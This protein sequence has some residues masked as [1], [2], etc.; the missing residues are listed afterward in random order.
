MEIRNYKGGDELKIVELF[1][2]VFNQKLSLDQW[3]WRFA[4]NP[5]D[6]HLISLMWDTD[7]LVGHYA[8]S[9]IL[10][11]VNGENCLTVHSLAYHDKF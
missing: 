8:V 1:E 11:D 5:V 9:P 6:N 4:Q 2:K 3:N 7:K 10:L